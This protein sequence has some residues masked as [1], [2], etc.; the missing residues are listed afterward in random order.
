[1]SKKI[2]KQDGP[3]IWDLQLEGI[4]VVVKGYADPLCIFKCSGGFGC[5]PASIGRAIFGSFLSD[6][7]DCRIERTEIVRVANDEDMVRVAAWEAM[8]PQEKWK[9]Q[10]KMEEK[11]VQESFD[12]LQEGFGRG[13]NKPS[14]EVLLDNY[15][16]L[17]RRY[18]KLLWLVELNEDHVANEMIRL[19]DESAAKAERKMTEAE[20]TEWV[21]SQDESG[22]VDQ[23][24]L[25]AAFAA[26]YSRPADDDDR[27]NGLWS[28]CCSM[29][30]NCGTRPEAE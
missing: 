11:Q 1:M 2:V 15:N 9:A 19:R 12:F 5:N 29:T 25:E 21:Y 16:L 3:N 26:L 6:G 8:T 13:K 23:D 22:E 28:L 7:E 17:W 14:K 4:T 10:L 18:Q 24:Q 30:P 20:A 27:Q